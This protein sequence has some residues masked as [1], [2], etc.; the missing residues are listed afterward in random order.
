MDQEMEKLIWEF[1]DGHLTPDER[2]KVVRQISENPE[3][4]IK[5]SE[6]ETTPGQAT[7]KRKNGKTFCI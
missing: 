2:E 4:Q 6:S 3:W 1:I 5:Y 7:T